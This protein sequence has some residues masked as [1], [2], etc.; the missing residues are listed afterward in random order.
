MFVRFL[1][2]S[3]RRSIYPGDSLLGVERLWQETLIGRASAGT[4]GRQICKSSSQ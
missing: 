2:I 1:Q 4:L 3:W